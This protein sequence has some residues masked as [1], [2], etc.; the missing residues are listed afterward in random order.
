[1]NRHPHG[2]NQNQYRQPQQ[3]KG[4]EG[5]NQGYHDNHGYRDEQGYRDGHYRGDGYNRGRGRSYYSNHN[6]N[7]YNQRYDQNDAPEEKPV[8]DKDRDVYAGLMTQ[9]EKDWVIKIQMFQLQT[10]NP[11]LDDYYYTVS[12]CI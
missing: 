3:W 1:M 4:R 10:D 7:N 5:Y 2:P 8:D 12:S 11:Y 9:K 6:Q